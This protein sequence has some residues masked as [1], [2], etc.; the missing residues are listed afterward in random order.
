VHPDYTA[1]NT[2]GSVMEAVYFR[3]VTAQAVAQLHGMGLAVDSFTANRSDAWQ[4]LASAGV[5][6]VIVDD[7]AGYQKWAAA[8]PG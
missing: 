6:W 5:D 2:T 4:A 1:E 3:N 8:P 7:V